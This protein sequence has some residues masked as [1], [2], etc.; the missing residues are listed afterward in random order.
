MKRGVMTMMMT[1]GMKRILMSDI[2][3]DD[4]RALLF[5]IAETW[6]IFNT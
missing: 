5:S 2:E 3:D 6:G 4:G 1:M